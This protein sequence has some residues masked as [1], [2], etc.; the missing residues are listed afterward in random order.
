MLVL[1]AI[2]AVI[3][4]LLIYFIQ[5]FILDNIQEK[6]II[7]DSF[8]VKLISCDLCFG[9]WVYTGLALVFNIHHLFTEVAMKPND[10]ILNVLD[11]Y[12]YIPIISE[13][14]TGMVFSFMMHI[15]RL[16]WNSKFQIIEVN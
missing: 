7:Q 8:L 1:F 4:R 12:V 6:Y 9:F 10:V 2:Y 15:F 11:G 3:G 14:F 13:I 16:G 5:K